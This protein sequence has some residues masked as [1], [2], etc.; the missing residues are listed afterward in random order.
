MN[1]DGFSVDIQYLKYDSDWR[2][3]IREYQEDLGAGRYETTWLKDAAEAME[4]RAKGA[5]DIYKENEYEEFWG[6]KQVL[7]RDILAGEAVKIQLSEL[8]RE[9]VL[10]VGDELHFR[11]AH[12]R[13][14]Q[15]WVIEKEMKVGFPCRPPCRTLIVFRSLTFRVPSWSLRFLLVGV[16]L[17]LSRSRM[18]ERSTRQSRSG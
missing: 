13:E 17:L 4:A 15:S 2:R 10:K 9:G 6:Q 7:H 11:R 14:G 16:G 12:N 18:I 8:V 3:F 5:F 1:E